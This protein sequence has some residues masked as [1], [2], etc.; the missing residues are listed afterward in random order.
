MYP[1]VIVENLIEED[2]LNLIQSS[3]H[4]LN[5]QLNPSAKEETYS[6][7]RYF[8]IGESFAYYDFI[9]K[10]DKKIENHIKAHY[11]KEVESYTGQSIVRYVEGQFIDI[12]K[13][14]EPK[15]EWVI[16]NNKKTV[17]LSSVFYF[18]D[19]YSGGDLVFYNNNKEK[20]FFIKPKKNCVI[21]FD[22]L[23]THSTI[24]I[25]SGVK[26]SYT[27]FYTLKD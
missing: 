10:I 24:P 3:F 7:L 21:L 26:Y 1:T 12:H 11:S 9:K 19:N 22:A 13:D 17:H 25:I 23:Q 15:D 5:F 4:D 18:N 14:W 6:T 16:L 20:Y 2:K 27:N 8:P